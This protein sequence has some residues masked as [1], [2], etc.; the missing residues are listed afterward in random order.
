M[1]INVRWLL[2]DCRSKR[3]ERSNDL[4]WYGKEQRLPCA[5]GGAYSSTYHLK[6]FQRE[7][8]AIRAKR[9]AA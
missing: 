3:T 2:A 8:A 9:L 7:L 4:A 6:S 1:N 5:G